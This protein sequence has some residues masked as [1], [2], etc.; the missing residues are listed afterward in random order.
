M[1]CNS[2]EDHCKVDTLRLIQLDV[3]LKGKEEKTQNMYVSHL[4]EL[5]SLKLFHSI[6]SFG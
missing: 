5:F 4:D 6:V 2:N 1:Q 3:E